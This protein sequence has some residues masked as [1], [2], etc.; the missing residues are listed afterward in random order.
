MG[1]K[2]GKRKDRRVSREEGRQKRRVGRKRGRRGTRK[3]ICEEWKL[4]RRKGV[5][6][7]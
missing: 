4:G 6:E 1:S 5:E 7:V 3:I 2:D